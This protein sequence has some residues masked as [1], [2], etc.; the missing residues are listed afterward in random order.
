M[1]TDELSYKYNST[2]SKIEGMN[3]PAIENLLAMEYMFNKIK[4]SDDTMTL[5]YNTVTSNKGDIGKT[6]NSDKVYDD[7]AVLLKDRGSNIN[8]GAGTPLENLRLTTFVPLSIASQDNV[9]MMG[10]VKIDLNST[11][12]K[13]VSHVMA[14]FIK[15]KALLQNKDI[16]DVNLQNI[17]ATIYEDLYRG[18]AQTLNEFKNYLY[19]KDSDIKKLYDEGPKKDE[20]AKTTDETKTDVTTSESKVAPDTKFTLGLNK[21]NQNSIVV[22]EDGAIKGMKKGDKIPLTE[23]NIKKLKALNS[24]EINSLI[25]EGIKF[26]LDVDTMAP[27]IGTPS[28][29]LTT[30]GKR[31]VKQINPQWQKLQDLQKSL[32]KTKKSTKKKIR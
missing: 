24:P 18:N 14:D 3:A 20:T 12:M 15:E 6:W 11:Q 29:Y 5:H 7:M 23:S 13:N 17:G 26:G 2:D 32:K 22:P 25:S 28:K 16:D 8:R 19:D 10:D 31:G 30:T 21:D 27:S 4:D 1:V 9:L